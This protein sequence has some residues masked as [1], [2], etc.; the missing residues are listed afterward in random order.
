MRLFYY[1]VSPSANTPAQVATDL[2][3]ARSAGVKVIFSFEYCNSLYC[4]EGVTV[5]QALSQIQ[6]FSQVIKDNTDVIAYVRTGTMGGWGEG[7]SWA[8]GDV[9]A[10]VRDPIWAKVLAIVPP[11]LQVSMPQMPRVA[12][13]DGGIP[14]SQSTAFTGSNFSR[15]AQE[16]YCFMAN[17]D[18]S[19]HFLGA[20]GFGGAIDPPYTHTAAQQRA[21]TAANTEFT[22]FTTE[23][24]LY[25]TTRD[26]TSR[27]S[28]YDTKPDN[29]GQLGGIMR[30]GPRYHVNGT[31]VFYALGFIDT[32][33]SE[34]CYPDVTNLMGYRF[35]L[36][37]ITHASTANKGDT[38]KV[39]VNIHDVGWGR[40]FSAR[41]LVVTL[42]NRSTGAEI[43]GTAG[44][45]RFLPSQAGISSTITTNVNVPS[46]AASGTYD[47]YLSV[48]DIYSTTAS[49][50]AFSVRF[51]NADTGSQSWDAS[52]ARFKTGT[53]ITVQ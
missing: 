53:A 8:T 11:Q 51:A 4:N 12:E 25:G 6:S 16:N 1:P 27:T 47:V 23:T 49:M 45:F 3:C 29:A 39:A 33:R 14:L 2:G 46:G 31:D 9:P 13:V 34:G 7:A 40:I 42:K 21:F 26:T 32:W 10:N 50:P 44:D 17:E 19:F 18:D 20:G 43:T 22:Y 35:Q 15:M 24:C 37:N 36:D 52:S 38:V 30:E 48:P 41:K 5:D 28:C